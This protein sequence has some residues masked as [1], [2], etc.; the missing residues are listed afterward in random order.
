LDELLA[1]VTRVRAVASGTFRGRALGSEIILETSD[2]AALAAFRKAL[3]IIENPAA[4][5]HCHCL[6]GPTLELVAGE[7]LLAAIGLHHGRFIRWAAWKHDA[8]L[9]NGRELTDWLTAHG[10]EGA[11]LRVLFNNQYDAGGL[12][13]VGVQ[14]KGATVLS[15]SEQ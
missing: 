14:R 11:L 8:Q 1:K 9:R 6:G 10:V 3:R 5:T 7:Q 4:F 2:V 15:R 12:M 13:P